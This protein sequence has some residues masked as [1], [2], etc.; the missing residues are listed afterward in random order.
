MERLVLKCALFIKHKTFKECF[1][2]FTVYFDQQRGG[3]PKTFK[4][5]QHVFE[6]FVLIAVYIV[7][8]KLFLVTPTL[9]YL[10]R[11]ERCV[12]IVRH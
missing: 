3:L 11:S 1:K 7:D 12:P 9:C 5:L 10:M 2:C 4:K 6:F 8:T